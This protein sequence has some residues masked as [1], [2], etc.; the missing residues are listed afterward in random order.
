LEAQMRESSRR[1]LNLTGLSE[2]GRFLVA[3]DS[4]TNESFHIPTDV[5]LTSWLDSGNA[6]TAKPD[7]Q[8]GAREP[9][10]D[11]SLSPRDIQNRIRRGES[12]EQVADESGMSLETVRGFA[13]PVIAE[14][15]YVVEQA[16]KTS[17][18][19]QHV[20]GSPGALLGPLV[21][22]SVAARGES[23][24]DVPWDSWRREDGRWSVVVSPAGFTQPATFLFDTKGRYVL[25]ADEAAHEL[26]GDFAITESSDM[27]IADALR[28]APA[29]PADTEIPTPLVE[30]PHP[31]ELD[32]EL[33]EALAL[34]VPEEL[35][36]QPASVASLKEARDRRAQ[37]Q[38][39][40][41]I[42]MSLEAGAAPAEIDDVEITENH[43][44]AEATP[45]KGKHERRRV[46]SWDEIMFG[47]A[48]R[49]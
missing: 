13:V 43:N 12:P 48:R 36:E 44:F 40:D 2:D 47:G 16:R 24:E 33:P 3:H 45:S 11:T 26:V 22:E 46:P 34:P 30:S 20:A 28:D 1:E 37:E 39:A 35:V 38:M 4:L 6:H 42:A 10:M 19:R 7:R 41:E 8:A 29:A 9:I 14:R 31:A 27:A 18:R 32:I 49:D 25:P 5:R 23:P 15:E 21:D 17:I